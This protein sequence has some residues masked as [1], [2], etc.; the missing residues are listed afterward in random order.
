[1]TPGIRYHSRIPLFDGDD[2][3][4]EC[5]KV[6]KTRVGR[7]DL[8]DVYSLDIAAATFAKIDADG[9]LSLG[10]KV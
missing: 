7:F 1:M 5:R 2:I 6:F 4:M 9:D 8:A 3:E 10:V